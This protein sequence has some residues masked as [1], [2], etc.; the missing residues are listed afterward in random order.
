MNAVEVVDAAIAR[1]M[2]HSRHSRRQSEA[3]LL[4]FAVGITG[5]GRSWEGAGWPEVIA[6][7]RAGDQV[8]VELLCR[9][10]EVVGL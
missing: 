8:A 3:G 2:R 10:V 1:A 7:A 6:A 9:H 4:Q 5:I